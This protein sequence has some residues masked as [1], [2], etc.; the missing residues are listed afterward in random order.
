MLQDSL[1]KSLCEWENASALRFEKHAVT[2][3][4]GFLGGC[5]LHLVIQRG[6]GGV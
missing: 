6:E 4:M 1:Q 2:R 3:W 5:I